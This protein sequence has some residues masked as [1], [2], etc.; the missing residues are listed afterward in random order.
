M[1]PMF[2]SGGRPNQTI[3]KLTRSS[4]SRQSRLSTPRRTDVIEH[5]SELSLLP[6]IYFV[7]SRKG[8]DQTASA[9]ANSRLALTTSE[10]RLEIRSIVARRTAHLDDDDLAVLGFDG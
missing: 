9:I 4:K 3:A 8:C 2:T 6:A 7:F 1:L 10:E 5:L